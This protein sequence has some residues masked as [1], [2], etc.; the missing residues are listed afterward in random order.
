MLTKDKAKQAAVWKYMQYASG[1][2][3]AKIVVANSGYAPTNSVVLEDEN[4]L[5]A[6]YA[7][8]ENSR[9]AHAQV[10]AYAGPW[11]AY[12]GSEGVA[13]TDLI[14]AALVEVVSGDDPEMTIKKLAED[15]RAKLNMK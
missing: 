6:F 1:P 9:V 5:G 2:E 4:Y 13:V 8:N 14:G 3:G 12:P 7:K 10:A 11:Y 15:V